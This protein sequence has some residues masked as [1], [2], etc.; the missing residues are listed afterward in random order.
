[1]AEARLNYQIRDD[2]ENHRYVIEVDGQVAGVA[3]YHIRKGRYI[4][5]H[6]EVGPEYEGKGLGSALARYALDEMRDRGETIVPI[7]PFIASYI[8]RHPEYQELVDRGLLDRI[9]GVEAE[10]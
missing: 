1:M 10:A 4:F 9:N 6:T 2:P 3:V 7:C 5:V 8:K